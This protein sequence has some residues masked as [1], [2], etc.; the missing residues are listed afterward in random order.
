[1]PEER[2]DLITY[3][4]IPVNQLMMTTLSFVTGGFN[5]V[6][7]LIFAGGLVLLIGCLNYSNLVV[8]QLSLRS[9]EIAVQK[10]L[11]S[12]RG[13]LVLQYCY[14]SLLFVGITLTVVISLAFIV[15]SIMSSA[16]IVGVGPALLLSPSL[17][18]AILSVAVVIVLLAGCYPALRTATVPLV[19]MMRPKG[20]GGYA[21]RMRAI[22]VGVQFFISG[23]LMIIVFVMFLQN[24]A[25]TQQL[26]GTVADPKLVVATPIDTFT[27]SPELMKTE[28]E[29]H[30]GVVSVTQSHITPW[31]ISSAGIALSQSEDENAPTVTAG[32]YYVAH[33]YP[34]TMDVEITVGRDFSRERTNDRYPLPSELQTGGGPYSVILDNQAALAFGFES[35]AAAVG[36]TLFMRDEL[37]D[38]ETEITMELMV[39]GAIESLNYQFVDFGSFGIQGNVLLLQPEIASVMIIK[40]SK[41]NVNEALQHIETTWNRLMPEIP[42]QREF[43]DDLFMLTYELFLSIS[44]AITV[45]SLLGFLIASIGLLGNVTFITNIRQKEVGIRKVMGA[46]SGRLL[47]MLLLDLAKPIIVANALAIPVG[48][49]IGTTYISLFAAR[50]ELTVMPFLISLMLSVLIAVG[51]VLPQS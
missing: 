31:S 36:E 13:L 24:G 20:S 9:Q 32:V 3:E 10:I 28:L 33:D 38:S 50:A 45:L 19:S 41:D 16:N 23:T 14:E 5:L 12:N 11:G 35:S 43:V 37:P 49:F 34:E 15:L 7:I 18:L 17:W 27:V 29:A 44:V 22:M 48:Y 46:S 4:I 21:G 47:R 25:M 40:I 51:A 2:R 26:D 30:P 8:A 42:L 1:L 39:I 6:N